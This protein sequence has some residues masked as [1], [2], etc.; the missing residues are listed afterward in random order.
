M[1]GTKLFFDPGPGPSKILFFGPGPGRGPGKILFF[2][3]GPGYRDRDRDWSRTC[4]TTTNIS[5]N[6]CNDI[7]EPLRKKPKLFLESLMDDI[8]PVVVPQTK[9]E[10]DL[11]IDF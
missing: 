3:P 8:A 5:S 10:V 7:N 11:Y 6:D 2:G 4:L 1:T 9:D